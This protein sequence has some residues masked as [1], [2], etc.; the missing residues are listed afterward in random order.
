MDLGL[1]GVIGAGIESLGG[2]ASNLLG[3]SS[4]RQQ[5][6]FQERMSDTAMQRR[7]ADLR[8]AGLNPILAAGGNS[9]STPSGTMFTPDNPLKGVTATIQQGF[10]N[11]KVMENLDAQIANT[12]AKTANEILTIPVL[13]EQARKTGFEADLLPI[14]AN[15]YAKTADK[16]FTETGNLALESRGLATQNDILAQKLRLAGLDITSAELEHLHRQYDLIPVQQRAQ[17][18][19][20]HPILTKIKTIFDSFNSSAQGVLG[21]LKD[22][23]SPVLSPFK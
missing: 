18:L 5:E 11:K 19:Q 1:S 22:L 20:D 14:Q 16:L 15:V 3:A 8:A 6:Q 13:K 9:A 12:N 21:G 23:I 7:T 2:L 10:M 4:A 17:F